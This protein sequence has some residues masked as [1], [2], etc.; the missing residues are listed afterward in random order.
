MQNVLSDDFLLD[1]LIEVVGYN[2]VLSEEAGDDASYVTE[3][4]SFEHNGQLVSDPF[5]D[6]TLRDE[7][8]PIDYYGRKKI[9]DM[10]TDYDKS[11]QIEALKN[12]GKA[13]SRLTE[14]WEL[15][16]SNLNDY[17]SNEYYPFERSFDEY[18]VP[19]FVNSMIED[20]TICEKPFNDDTNTDFITE[21]EKT[22]MKTDNKIY[23]VTMYDG[24]GIQYM[25]DK[26]LRDLAK[27]YHENSD[28][29]YSINFYEEDIFEAIQWVKRAD[30]E[31][32]VLNGSHNLANLKQ[33]NELLTHYPDFRN[34]DDKITITI[35]N[36]NPF[37]LE[38]NADIFI[39]FESFVDLALAEEE[40]ECQ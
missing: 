40:E 5:Y 38:M 13:Y 12:F 18:C 23:K 29:K 39:K 4:I 14:V 27:Y 32:E 6:E 22:N 1:K 20:L 17:P 2:T 34:D 24:S 9:E 21:E 25:T 16:A 37:T 7:V 31:V 30:D 28:V 35:G 26:E 3:L 8:N 11:F 10:V 15:E 33:L 36:S 19:E